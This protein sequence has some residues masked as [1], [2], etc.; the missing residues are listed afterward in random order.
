MF[1]LVKSLSLAGLLLF[2]A[3]A[4]ECP[5]LG[6]SPFSPFQ[7]ISMGAELNKPY[8]EI[9]YMGQI[10]TLEN[11]S[12]GHNGKNPLLSPVVAA[13]RT[14]PPVFDPTTGR[15]RVP[16]NNNFIQ[17][18]ADNT[19]LG[20]IR[21]G[22]QNG[23]CDGYLEFLNPVTSMNDLDF[24]VRS[25]FTFNLS[26]ELLDLG[27]T[28]SSRSPVTVTAENLT[29]WPPPVGTVY[30]QKENVDLVAEP[31][32]PTIATLRPDTTVITNVFQPT[33]VPEPGNPDS[34]GS[35]PVPTTPD[36]SAPHG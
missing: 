19:P 17:F 1:K 33:P 6:K 26:V 15:W 13:C 34:S 36:S 3:F 27:V 16:I 35:T 32:G 11:L 31:G 8:T 29:S 5:L 12:G 20:R 10:Y 24:P 22:A 30:S 7:Q 18:S 2:F 28:L 9:E 23:E 4:A 14:N 21:I 25:V